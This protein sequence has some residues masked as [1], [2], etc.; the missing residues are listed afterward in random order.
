VINA[1][2]DGPPEPGAKPLGPF[3]ELE[4]SSPALALAP[5]ASYEHQQTTFHFTGSRET[6]DPIARKCLGV[7][8][9]AIEK[10]FA[11]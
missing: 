11:K 4:T 1:Y 10:A 9:E 8:L 6:L 5:G 3:F 2:N 7:G